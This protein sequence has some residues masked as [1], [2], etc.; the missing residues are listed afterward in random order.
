M[1]KDI[2]GNE[3]ENAILAFLER[4][5]KTDK[6][7]PSPISGV[8]FS[9]VPLVDTLNCDRQQAEALFSHP[10]E[11]MYDEQD[12]VFINVFNEST[13]IE[14]RIYITSDRSAPEFE[15]ICDEIV[16]KLPDV[17]YDLG[18]QGYVSRQ[19]ELAAIYKVAIVNKLQDDQYLSEI[20]L[21]L[22]NY[23]FER[24]CDEHGEFAFTKLLERVQ[25]EADSV[26]RVILMC[27]TSKLVADRIKKD[28]SYRGILKVQDAE[29]LAYLAESN[30]TINYKYNKL[31]G[32]ARTAKEKIELGER[33]AEER[34]ALLE[35]EIVTPDIL[36]L[37]SIY[38]LNQNAIPGRAKRK[39]RNA[40]ARYVEELTSKGLMKDENTASEF[41]KKLIKRAQKQFLSRMKI[42]RYKLW[43]DNKR[44]NL[45]PKF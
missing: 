41:K 31:Y 20:K 26:S 23:D 37:F 6:I 17:T 3:T 32:T 16:K 24:I 38:D 12:Q 19:A 2:L 43:A 36:L 45:I 13:K 34:K 28:T 8:N 29:K 30:A 35:S 9:G 39:I 4:L 1:V 44:E 27:C 10:T 42:I 21:I 7:G 5:D 14:E 11:F 33:L 15:N 25:E 18:G 40:A 22:R